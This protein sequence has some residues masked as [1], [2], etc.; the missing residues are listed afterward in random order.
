[1]KYSLLAAALVTLTFSA[2]DQMREKTPGEGKPGQYPPSLWDKREGQLSDAEIDAA[3]KE[4][5][6]EAESKKSTDDKPA[7]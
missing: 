1:M 5:A 2:C 3:Q 7:N 4:S 6:A